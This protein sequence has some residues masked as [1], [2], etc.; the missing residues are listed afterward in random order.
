MYSQNVCKSVIQ[1]FAI[2]VDNSARLSR[3]VLIYVMKA[4]LFHLLSLRIVESS[5]PTFAAAVASKIHVGEPNFL[6]G[7]S[8]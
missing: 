7:L 4:A 6:K 8:D 5:N 1:A 2:I 3:G